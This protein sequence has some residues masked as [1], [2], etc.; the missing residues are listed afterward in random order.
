MS[1]KPG[2][3]NSRPMFIDH[4]PTNMRPAPAPKQPA[5]AAPKP[6]APQKQKP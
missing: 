4:M 6:P 1:K 3:G 2:T 5:P